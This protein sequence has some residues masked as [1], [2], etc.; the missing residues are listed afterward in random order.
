MPHDPADR[1]G[2]EAVTS[3]AAYLFPGRS[4]CTCMD[5]LSRTFAVGIRC[6]LSLNRAVRASE[7]AQIVTG[8]RQRD[9]CGTT[10]N[11]VGFRA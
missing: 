9:V 10:T 1:A 2:S 4:D 8:A 11:P 6:D 3:P 7:H 5:R